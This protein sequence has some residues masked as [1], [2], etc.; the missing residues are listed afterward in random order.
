MWKVY[1][2]K[3]DRPQATRKAHLSFQSRWENGKISKSI[4]D[5]I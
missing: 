1:I 5:N 4:P 2:K 3:D